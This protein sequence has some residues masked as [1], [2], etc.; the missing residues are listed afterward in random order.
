MMRHPEHH[1]VPPTAMQ[2]NRMNMQQMGPP[3]QRMLMTVP[4]GPHAGV[5]VSMPSGPTLV[6]TITPIQ[7]FANSKSNINNPVSQ[8]YYDPISNEATE[9]SVEQIQQIQHQPS[10]LANTTTS[11]TVPNLAN[12]KEKTPMCLVNELA[13]YNKIQHQYRLTGE[14]GP[15]HKKIFTVTLKLGEEEYEAEGASI[16]KAQHS[17]AALALEKTQFR[18]PPPKTNRILRTGGIRGNSTGMVTPTVELN[19]LAMKRGERTVYIVENG[20]APPAQGYILPNAY[21]GRQNIYQPPGQPRYNSFETRR[22]MRG[23]YQYDRHHGEREYPGSGCT[24][25]AARHD[26]ATKAIDEIKKLKSEEA[27]AENEETTK[28]QDQDSSLSDINTELKSPISLVHEIA[29]KRH[30]NVSFEVKSENGPPHM[31]VFVTQCKIGD[32]SVEGEGN[33]KKVSKKRAAEEMLKKLSQLPPLPNMNNVTHLKRKRV[34]TKKKTRNLIKVNADKPNDFVEDINPISRLIQ[35]QQA[36]KEKEPVYAVV[37]ERGAPRRREFVIQASINGC[38]A[39][40]VGPNKKYAKRNAAQALLTLMGYITTSPSPTGASKQQSQQT[41][42]TQTQQ[43][44]NKS[45][46][47]TEQTTTAQQADKLRKVTFLEEKQESPPVGG[48]GGRQLVPGLLLVGDQS[49]HNNKSKAT[50]EN[51]NYSSSETKKSVP[52]VAPPPPQGVR[53]KDQLLYL[54][55]IMDIPIQFSDFPKANHEMYLT[56][57][58]LSTTPPQV[59]HGEGPTIEASHEKASLEALNVL[60]EMGLDNIAPSKENNSEMPKPQV[61]GLS[62]NGNNN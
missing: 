11:S 41:S 5:L 20:A 40:G 4:G 58:S 53:S 32:C 19:A 12:M 46:K 51:T 29:L 3:P 26:A 25:Q 30:L 9:L 43:E 23:Q 45:E 55:Q 27:A 36:N 6:N 15:A 56:L 37:E 50:A 13:R 49:V 24:I 39:N 59:C 34:A 42:P 38:S 21:Y 28:D 47:E 31:K 61:A 8:V 14:Q 52:K 7:Q 33:G 48:S 60:S 18:R 62:Q 10:Q 22:N 16:K 35:I 44:A 57:V 54:A 2:R 17:A 1:H